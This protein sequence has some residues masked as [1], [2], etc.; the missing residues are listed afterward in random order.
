M[1]NKQPCVVIHSTR[2][3]GERFR[4]SDWVDRISSTVASFG[5]DRRLRYAPAVHPRVINGERCLVVDGALA[6]SRPG[7]YQYILDFARSNRLKMDEDPLC[8]SF[9]SG[10]CCL[11]GAKGG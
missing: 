9:S 10:P 3:D 6:D 4:P 1:S 8:R 5:P 11:R 7:V 2:E